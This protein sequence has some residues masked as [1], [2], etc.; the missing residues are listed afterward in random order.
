MALLLFTRSFEREILKHV[1]LLWLPNYRQLLLDS[2]LEI[3]SLSPAAKM[4]FGC[5]WKSHHVLK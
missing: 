3:F 1:G 5:N 4:V 2:I